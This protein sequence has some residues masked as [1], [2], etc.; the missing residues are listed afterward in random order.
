M[1]YPL[2]KRPMIMVRT[3]LKPRRTTASGAEDRVKIQDIEGFQHKLEKLIE[4]TYSDSQFFYCCDLMRLY[5]GRFP[6]SD[7]NDLYLS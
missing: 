6:V 5:V 1:E 2:L 4:K 3:P 7:K